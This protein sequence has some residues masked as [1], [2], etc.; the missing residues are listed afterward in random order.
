MLSGHQH[1]WHLRGVRVDSRTISSPRHKA[2]EIDPLPSPF[3][4]LEQTCPRGSLDTISELL[5]INNQLES[6][7]EVLR[8]A[9]DESCLVPDTTRRMSSRG[10]FLMRSNSPI[11]GAIKAGTTSAEI[12]AAFQSRP[13]SNPMAS[14]SSTSG[15]EARRYIPFISEP[16]FSEHSRTD[17]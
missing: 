2:Q 14:Q 12:F 16:A 11:F 7:I 4:A 1:P 5:N 17:D 15:S 8:S 3:K 9:S 10:T 13:I 6:R